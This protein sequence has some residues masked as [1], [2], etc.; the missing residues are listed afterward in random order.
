MVHPE[1]RPLSA[2]EPNLSMQRPRLRTPL[3]PTFYQI[4]SSFA[5][6]KIVFAIGVTAS[7]PRRYETVT[8]PPTG[9]EVSATGTVVG[10]YSVA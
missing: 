5:P 9:L 2:P 8:K 6:I 4:S 7:P 10:N 1:L 3:K